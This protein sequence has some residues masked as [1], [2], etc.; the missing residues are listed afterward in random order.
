MR[1][2]VAAV[3]G[4]DTPGDVDPA[5]PFKDL[6][7]D[8]LGAVELRN[9]LS[10]AT[11]L[12]LPSTL[13]FDHPTAESLAGLVLSEVDG[14]VGHA[15][16]QSPV[17]SQLSGLEEL[18]ATLKEG[19]KDDVAGRLRRILKSLSGDESDSAADRLSEAVTLDDVLDVLGEEY[20]E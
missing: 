12:R 8:S 9:R 13:A 14:V 17:D 2:Q 3:L 7:F 18:V 15:G 16:P 19:E 4:Y 5:R 1:G 6:G 10:Q 20:G 11:G